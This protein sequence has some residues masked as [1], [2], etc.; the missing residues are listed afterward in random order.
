MAGSASTLPLD[1]WSTRPRPLIACLP[2]TSTCQSATTRSLFRLP[3]ATVEPARECCECQ[4][5]QRQEYACWILRISVPSVQLAPRI[6]DRIG[7]SGVARYPWLRPAQTMPAPAAASCSS[8]RS[9]RDYKQP[10]GGP[11]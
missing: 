2:R 4:W 3:T 8:F 5:D 6:P 7:L 1:Y 11:G 9:S 10:L